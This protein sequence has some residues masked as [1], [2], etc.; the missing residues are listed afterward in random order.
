MDFDGILR[1]NF[2]GT[3]LH[4]LLTFSL[5]PTNILL[6]AILIEIIIIMNIII[7]IASLLTTTTLLLGSTHVAMTV[8]AAVDRS[9][10]AATSSI[11]RHR[12]TTTVVVTSDEI[13]DPYLGLS[14][15]VSSKGN[16]E[17]PRR[18]RVLQPE[19]QEGKPS[20]EEVEEEKEPP[21][22]VAGSNANPNL[23]TPGKDADVDEE[24]NDKP[25]KV[26]NQDEEM[27]TD[28]TEGDIMILPPM[29]IEDML[30]LSMPPLDMSMPDVSSESAS[31]SM[32]METIIPTY[33][34][35]VIEDGMPTYMPT[36][37]IVV[38]EVEE[39]SGATTSMTMTLGTTTIAVV[40][41]WWTV[42]GMTLLL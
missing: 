18:R 3:K 34:P 1:R 32:S 5:I 2:I 12:T 15:A 40:A 21:A 35:T 31:L 4:S 36:P 26:V 22:E 38:L 19:D 37:I 17:K 11:R 33:S 8:A 20:K 23:M 9:T 27:T 41:V 42:T 30:S 25:A 29:I 28:D 39:T 7:V 24:P 6:T 14:L 10:T 16:S 13:Y